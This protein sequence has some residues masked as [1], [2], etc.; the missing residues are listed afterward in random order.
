MQQRFHALLERLFGTTLTVR[1]AGRCFCY[2]FQDHIRGP[3]LRFSALQKRQ[4]DDKG[5]VQAGYGLM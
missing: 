2:A 3:G 4:F 1:H 5:T